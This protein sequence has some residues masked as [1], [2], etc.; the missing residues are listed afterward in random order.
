[1]VPAIAAAVQPDTLA[2]GCGELA[3]HLRRYRLLSCILEHGLRP[4]GVGLG[5]IADGF[6]AVDAVFQ[7]R[8]VQIGHARLDGIIEALEA[9]F[10]FGG[11]LVQLGDMLAAALGMFFPAIQSGGKNG[12]QPLGLEKLLLKVIGNQIVQLLHRH[13]HALAGGRSLP[14]LH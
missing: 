2:G 12:F 14:R 11:A 9:Q 7:R 10:R 4:V 6:E 13:G 1:V 5:L 3:Q 8:V